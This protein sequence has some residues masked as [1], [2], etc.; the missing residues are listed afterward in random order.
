MVWETIEGSRKVKED[1]EIDAARV[2]SNEKVVGDFDKG[3]LSAMV[4]SEARLKGFIEFKAGHV[5]LELVS[6]CSFQN[7]TQE[8]QVRNWTIVVEVVQVQTRLLQNGN[9]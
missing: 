7:L 3:G 6:H 4:F 8:W 9:N 1:E 5:F 2:S